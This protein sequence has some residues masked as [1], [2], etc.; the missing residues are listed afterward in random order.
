MQPLTLKA[1]AVP[2][3]PERVKLDI[4]L[5]PTHFRSVPM[6]LRRIAWK[7]RE[8]GLDSE[9]YKTAIAAIIAWNTK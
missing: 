6:K 4:S 3:C 5:C 2:D 1:C 8:Q 9:Q 7:A